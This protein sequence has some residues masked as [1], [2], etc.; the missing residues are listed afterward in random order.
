MESSAAAAIELGSTWECP[1]EGEATVRET[2][3]ELRTS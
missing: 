2:E 1:P 3:A